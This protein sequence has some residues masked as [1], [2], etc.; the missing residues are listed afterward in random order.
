M[1]TGPEAPRVN[2]DREVD[3]DHSIERLGK[4]LTLIGSVIAILVGLNTVVTGWVA[5][6]EARE[7]SFREALERE[8]AFWRDRYSEFVGLFGEGVT[9]DQR[10]ARLFVLEGLAARP[11]AHFREFTSWTGDNVGKAQAADRIRDL[12]VRLIEALSSEALAGREVAQTRQVR[13]FEETLA[14]A[15]QETA[16]GGASPNDAAVTAATPSPERIV[17]TTQV[18]SA[19]KPQGWDFDVFWCANPNP[20]VAA[21]NYREGLHIATFL[22]SLDKIPS[23]QGSDE[24]GRVRLASLP[25][26]RQGGT[27]PRTGNGL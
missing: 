5:R 17:F 12:R 24:R 8:E 19:G 27:Y 7:E 1:A 10:R 25:Q 13:N 21:E 23:G 26:S 18:L 15:N 14:S 20:A 9:L 16:S 3:S 6:A 2:G 4:R 22:A 11:A